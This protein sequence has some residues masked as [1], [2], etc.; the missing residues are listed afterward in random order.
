LDFFRYFNRLIISLEPNQLD[1]ATPNR[2]TLGFVI[3]PVIR[4]YTT[5]QPDSDAE[6]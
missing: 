1:R 2:C 4:K 5:A 6:K 3:V